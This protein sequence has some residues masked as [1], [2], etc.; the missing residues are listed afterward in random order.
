MYWHGKQAHHVARLLTIN[1][2]GRTDGRTQQA[3][4]ESSV[5]KSSRELASFVCSVRR[6]AS[7]LSARFDPHT[8]TPFETTE[9]IY[10][11]LPVN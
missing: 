5:E 1:K 4:V 8:S 2:Q 6:E 7:L 3:R 11:L 10:R 9:I